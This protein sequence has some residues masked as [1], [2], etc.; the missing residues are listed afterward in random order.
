MEFTPIEKIK[1]LAN[2]IDCIRGSFVCT[3][4]YL[5]SGDVLYCKESFEEVCKSTN[6]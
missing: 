4:V 6:K 2:E 5:L 1:E 3:V